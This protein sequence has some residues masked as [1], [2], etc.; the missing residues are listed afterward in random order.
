MAVGSCREAATDHSPGLQPWVTLPHS[1]TPSQR[2]AGFEDEDENEAPQ[3]WRQRRWWCQHVSRIE[4]KLWA[5]VYNR[6]ALD[7]M[8]RAC[9]T[10]AT[11]RRFPVRLDLS[12]R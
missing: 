1:N 6:F 5:M 12:W 3:E 8:A 11:K 4:V 2:V 9:L 7:P 10:R